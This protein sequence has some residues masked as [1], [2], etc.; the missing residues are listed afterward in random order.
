M[1]IRAMT[2]TSS[3]SSSIT[4][5]SLLIQPSK[6]L[7][8]ANHSVW[9]AQVR[10][11]IRGAKLMGY[12]TGKTTAPPSEIPQIGA[13]GKGVKNNARQ[14]IMI[15]NLSMKIGTRWTSKF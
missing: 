2:N 13:D 12:L 11:A 9:H 14:V 10:V 5:N 15:P 7:T 4:N 8:K 6:K 3:N 1:V